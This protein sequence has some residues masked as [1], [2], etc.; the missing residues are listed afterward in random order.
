MTF[1]RTSILVAIDIIHERYS[2][3]LWE[4]FTPGNDATWIALIVIISSI[5]VYFGT[6]YFIAFCTQIIRRKH[7]ESKD[8]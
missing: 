8:F 1:I 4:V 7:K 6:Y 5:A 2:G 3:H